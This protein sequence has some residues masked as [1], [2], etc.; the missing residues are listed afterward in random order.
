MSDHGGVEW[1]SIAQWVAP[2]VSSAAALLIALWAAFSRRDEATLSAIRD[3]I[4]ELRKDDARLFERVDKVEQRMATVETEIK[5]LPTRE[6]VHR[7]DVKITGIAAT[8]EARFESLS[9]QIDTLISQNERAQD[10]LAERED[11]K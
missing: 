2:W 11:R 1:G 8:L 5:H 3:D 7:I 4:D 6:E 9:R 10:R